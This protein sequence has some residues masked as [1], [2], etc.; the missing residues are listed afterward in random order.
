M[1]MRAIRDELREARENRCA[2]VAIA[3]FSAAH[4]PTGV[5][6]FAIVGDDVYAV[7]DPADPELPTLEAAV[8]LARLLA[9]ASLREREVEID[10]SVISAAL[11]GIREQ[12]D[13][14]RQL[15]TQLPRSAMR[16][17]ACGPA[18]TS[19]ARRS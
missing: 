6:P 4:A 5:A 17:R 10:P 2:S 15:K 8:R 16:P 13:A 19:F 14:I 1:S 12:L 11:S 18:S 7:V 3:V 9:L